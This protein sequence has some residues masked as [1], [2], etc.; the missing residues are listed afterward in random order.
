MTKDPYSDTEIAGIVDGVLAPEGL[1]SGA[2]GQPF[3]RVVGAKR[4]MDATDPRPQLLAALPAVL[5]TRLEKEGEG[6]SVEA[7]GCFTVSDIWTFVRAVTV[8]RP[9]GET[10]RLGVTLSWSPE[11]A[12]HV[13]AD[14]IL[15][16]LRRIT[17]RYLG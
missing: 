10:P 2:P 5:W 7:F 3:L 6:G 17:R 11:Y 16:V 9:E 12:E 14:K 8:V 15:Q 1:L 13:E 4:G